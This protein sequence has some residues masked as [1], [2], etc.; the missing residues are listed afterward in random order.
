M[1]VATRAGGFLLGAGL[2]VSRGAPVLTADEGS[3]R[4]GF[5]VQKVVPATPFPSGAVDGVLPPPPATGFV[6]P[7]APIWLKNVNSVHE[8]RLT[9]GPDLV[10]PPLSGTSAWK[11]T[12]YPSPATAHTAAPAFVLRTEEALASA[13]AHL[14]AL[15]AGPVGKAFELFA[16]LGAYQPG[17]K[18]DVFTPS[19][20]P[21]P[22]FRGY[23][24]LRA[25]W[26]RSQWGRPGPV[27]FGPEK[28]YVYPDYYPFEDVRLR[29]ARLYCAARRAQQE[30]AGQTLSL[31]E[32]AAFSVKVLGHTIDFLVVE[33]TLALGRDCSEAP[34]DEPGPARF[35]GTMDGVAPADGAQ[36]FEIP[37]LLGNRVTPIRGLGLPG[38]GEVR[39]PVSLVTGDTEVRTLAE[40]RP[41][42]VGWKLGPDGISPSFL[43]M[44]SKEYHTVTHTDAI[45]STGFFGGN[46]Y[47][48]SGEFTLF[49][50]GPVRVFGTASLTYTI[51][52][53]GGGNDR[54]LRGFPAGWPA[55]DREGRLYENPFQLSP[56]YGVR[57][58]DG[59]WMLAARRGL[60]FE[61]R[62]QPEGATDPFW[63]SPIFPVFRPHDM[64]AVTDDDHVFDTATSMA[65]GL[66]LAGQLGIDGGPFEV[67]LTVGGHV[68]GK[69]GQH[70]VL[71]DALMAQDPLIPGF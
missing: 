39:V 50:V 25:R 28:K 42:F 43:T 10:A 47:S 2:L 61:W 60:F 69:V 31:G 13:T 1:R 44:P 32:R 66:G 63:R 5:E 21:A 64:R 36:A 51:G 22:V 52:E 11:A 27:G 45:L 33:P 34:C 15:D 67:S 9:W 65:L 19:A 26:L 29:G 8:G 55:D 20:P 59:P 23:L 71:R 16:D 35:I 6:L 41:V 38:L 48:A 30:Q 7:G 12:F 17:A 18:V 4:G 37:L 62:V 24:P 49:Y 53:P 46:V 58:H 54:V 40:K 14:G 3:V 68:T 70:H 56:P 57:Y